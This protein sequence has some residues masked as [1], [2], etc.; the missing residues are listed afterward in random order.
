MFVTSLFYNLGARTLADFVFMN[1]P[2]G[3]LMNNDSDIALTPEEVG[4]LAESLFYNTSD[5]ATVAIELSKD[6]AYQFI[7]I[8]KM[9]AAVS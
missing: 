3:V 9:T 8:S 4:V 5:R 1:P 6:V 2:W 7:I